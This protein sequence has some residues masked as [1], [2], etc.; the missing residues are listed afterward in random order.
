LGPARTFPPC[1]HSTCAGE[2]GGCDKATCE[3]VLGWRAAAGHSTANDVARRGRGL[4]TCLKLHLDET[5]TSVG[6]GCQRVETWIA[7]GLGVAKRAGYSYLGLG[8][9]AR[10]RGDHRGRPPPCCHMP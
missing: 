9:L 2:L 4:P 7:G 6:A 1:L 3:T 10:E 5:G 8:A